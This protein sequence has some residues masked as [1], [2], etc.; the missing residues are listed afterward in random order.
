MV[1][2]RFYLFLQY[3]KIQKGVALI[4]FWSTCYE[5]KVYSLY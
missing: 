1:G 5:E 3:L 2:S 4:Y